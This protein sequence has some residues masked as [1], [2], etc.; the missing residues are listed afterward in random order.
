MLCDTFA[1]KSISSPLP[2]SRGEPHHAGHTHFQKSASSFGRSWMSRDMRTLINL[3]CKYVSFARVFLHDRMLVP[4]NP[5][6]PS[7]WRCQPGLVAEIIVD[8]FSSTLVQILEFD[9]ARC[10]RVGKICWLT[11]RVTEMAMAPHRCLPWHRSRTVVDAERVVS[12]CSP[13]LERVNTWRAMVLSTVCCSCSSS[14]S[15]VSIGRA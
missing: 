1:P 4:Y 15:L 13:D 5:A 8:M 6:R 14:P 3:S 7:F 10:R 12:D 2:M 11:L 9:S